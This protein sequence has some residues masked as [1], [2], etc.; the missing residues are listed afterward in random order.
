VAP[1]PIDSYLADVDPQA[2]ALVRELDAAVRSAH[3]GFDVAI[4]YRIPTYALGEDWRFWT[5]AVQ[6]T[7]KVVSLRFLYGV[8]LEDPLHVLRKGSSVLMSWDH[9]VD[10]PVHVAA[11]GDYVREAVGKH[12]YY[13]AHSAE[14]LAQA[15]QRRAR[16]GPA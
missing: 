12:A 7:G 9:A 14:I 6:A 11:V 5:C 3:D 2:H 1:D 4:K 13:K 8:L 10:A 15:R 16:A